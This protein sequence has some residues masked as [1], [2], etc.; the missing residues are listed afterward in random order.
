MSGKVILRFYEELN[1]HLP[2]HLR[3]KDFELEFEGEPTIQELIES[4]GVPSE[5]V[6]LILAQGRSVGFGYG[7]KDGERVS[8]YPIFESINIAEV[9]QLPDRPLRT[10]KFVV[11]SDLV[12]LAIFMAEEGYDIRFNVFSSW[13]EIRSISV[14][15]ERIIL[16]THP[17]LVQSE[18]VTHAILLPLASPELQLEK[19]LER[20]DVDRVEKRSS[21]ETPALHLT[22]PER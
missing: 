7:P 16:S 6:D 4:L 1:F 22:Y 11:D 17:A 19:L 2:E 12:D 21:T 5:E 15:E 18:D 3:K 13:D 20:L 9:T 14:K 10:T 8:V